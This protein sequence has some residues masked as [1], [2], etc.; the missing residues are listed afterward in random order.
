MVI[1]NAMLYNKPG[2]KIHQLALRVQAVAT[3]ALDGL[4][5]L[6]ISHLGSADSLQQTIEPTVEHDGDDIPEERIPAQ[7]NASVGVDDDQASSSLVQPLAQ[8]L[9][10]IG[11]LEPPLALLNLLVSKEAIQNDMRLILDQD[12]LQ[13]LFSFE[14]GRGKPL[15]PPPPPSLPKGKAPKS[16]PAKVKRDRKAENE[17]RKKQRAEA[18]AAAAIAAQQD[19]VK[20]EG[21]DEMHPHV[22]LDAVMPGPR[23]RRAVAAAEAQAEMLPPEDVTSVST[24]DSLSRRGPGATKRRM[25]AVHGEDPPMVEDV[26]SQESFKMFH[27]GWVLPEGQRRKGRPAPVLETQVAPRPKKKTKTGTGT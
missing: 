25:S 10:P 11:D 23:T 27:E 16:K 8:P 19:L 5:D 1:D 20:G 3:T 17:K 21:E 18:A 7:P 26:G 2:S 22:Q 13:S 6:Q 9:E 12:P 14:W 15:P 4:K 24:G